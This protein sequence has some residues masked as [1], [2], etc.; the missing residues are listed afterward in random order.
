MN[1]EVAIKI[2]KATKS[3]GDLVALNQISL[4]IAAGSTT[5]FLGPNGAGKTT[6]LQT[7]MGSISI[8]SGHIS[9]FDHLPGSTGVRLRSGAMLQVTGVPAT[10]TVREHVELF[11]CYYLKPLNFQNLIHLANL[12]GLER[13]KYGTLS[14]G[15]KQRLHFAL[16]IAG[17]PELLFLDEPTVAMDVETRLSFWNQVSEFAKKDCTVLL[18]TH[19]LEEAEFLADRIILIDRGEIVVDA[20]PENI[21]SILGSSVVSAVTKISAEKL[22][23]LPGVLDVQVIADRAKLIVSSPEETVRAWL[24]LDSS[25]SRLEVKSAQLQDAYL[26]LLGQET[27]RRK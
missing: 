16:A 19:N 7:I 13:R 12:T 26:H 22:K 1:A 27:S 6:L 10:L 14:G 23:Q 20:T 2:D 25:L 3:Y 18:N 4:S 17:D 21:R 11:R 8:D 15:E 5:A 24:G 9:V